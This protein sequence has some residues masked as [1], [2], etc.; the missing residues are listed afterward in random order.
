MCSLVLVR[1]VRD[2]LLFMLFSGNFLDNMWFF[3]ICNVIFCEN[4]E[5]SKKLLIFVWN[6]KKE[7][8]WF[9]GGY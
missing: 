8:Y 3:I 6:S 4:K 5:K 9:Y 1:V 2:K 7:V